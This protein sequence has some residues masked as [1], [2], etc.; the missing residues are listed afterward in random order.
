MSYKEKIEHTPCRES[1][2]KKVGIGDT[3]G[4]LTLVKAVGKS[5]NGSRVF[6][7]ECTCGGKI[8]VIASS[9]N[10]GLTQSCGCLREET[11]RI[12]NSTHGM[13]YYQEY[14]IWCGM[15]QRCYN[16]ST[17]YYY[18]YG[19]KG[20]TVCDRWLGEEGFKSFYDDMGK[21]PEKFL[22]DRIDSDGNYEPSNCRWVDATTSARNTKLRCNN[23]SG[24]KGVSWHSA[25]KKWQVTIS[26]DGKQKYL[27][28]FDNL[29][30]AIEARSNAETEFNY[31][32]ECCV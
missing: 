26:V 11:K 22:I 16:P 21:R 8:E 19:G 27:G 4:R 2:Y 14:E 25:H 24:K 12:R 13:S 32:G 3:V 9:L 7:C 30:K 10:S 18:L 6:L 28:V 29:D 15:K 5:S 17:D 31:F 20:V 23:T 1:Q